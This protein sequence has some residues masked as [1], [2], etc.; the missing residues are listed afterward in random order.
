[1]ETNPLIA[2]VVDH[3]KLKQAIEVLVKRYSTFQT[4]PTLIALG[5]QQKR[6]DNLYPP[7][8]KVIIELI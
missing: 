7:A 4:E 2:D 8:H 3:I 1:V 5:L 6:E